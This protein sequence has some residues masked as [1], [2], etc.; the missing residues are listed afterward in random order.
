MSLFFETLKIENYKILNSKQHNKRLNRTIYEVFGKKSNFNISDFV[1]IPD[2]K[3]YR[4]KVIYNEKIC[5]IKLLSYK[6]RQFN[7]FKIVQTKIEYPYKSVDRTEI[8]SLFEQRGFCDDIIMVKD[9]LVCDTSIAN[10]AIYDGLKWYTPKKPLFY[11]TQRAKLLEDKIIVEKEIKVKDFKNIVSFA[12]M[13]AL[14]GFR[15][16]KDVQFRGL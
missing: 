8:D 5:S 16:V 13:N 7:S 3:C 10:I 2:S 12:I 14:L 15:V 11:G 4:C 9:S 1:K 6:P